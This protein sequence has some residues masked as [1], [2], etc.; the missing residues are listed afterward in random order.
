M[1]TIK[2]SDGTELKGLELNGNNFI[3]PKF[4]RILYS[5]ENSA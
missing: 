4:L 1:Y 3:A 5:R 2:L